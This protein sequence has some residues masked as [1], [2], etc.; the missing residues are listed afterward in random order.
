M[1]I[2]APNVL[3]DLHASVCILNGV[4]AVYLST[5]AHSVLPNFH[6]ESDLFLDNQGRLQPPTGMIDQAHRIPMPL[7]PELLV[8]AFHEENTDHMVK[9]SCTYGPDGMPDVK[10]FVPLELVLDYGGIT[11]PYLSV[12]GDPVPG[13]VMLPALL[14]Q[15]HHTAGTVHSLWHS[16]MLPV[17]VDRDY[18]WRPACRCPR[19]QCLVNGRWC[20]DQHGDIRQRQVAYNSS[21]PSLLEVYWGTRSRRLRGDDGRPPSPH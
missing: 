14:Y 19:M 18:V 16:G 20:L 3:D 11:Y 10:S 17:T 6:V 4:P 7:T 1:P 13:F 15:P 9:C 5:S 21:I 2:P 8:L 12:D